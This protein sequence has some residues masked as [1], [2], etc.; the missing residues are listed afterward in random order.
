MSKC[1]RCGLCCM[2]RGDLAYGDDGVPWYEEIP[3]PALLFDEG[4]A[5]CDVY[6]C[7][8]SVCHD[9]PFS[10]IDD[11][12]CERQ[13][14]VAAVIGDHLGIKTNR[15]AS[16]W[17]AKI[18]SEDNFVIVA[19][20]QIHYAVKSNKIPNENNVEDICYDASNFTAFSRP[21]EIYI[22]E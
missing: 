12:L 21:N 16:N 10:D 13:L 1:L 2:G 20:C 7:R 15:N 17:F 3:C 19:G 8:L 18:G 5:S 14:R 4:V 22:A 11:G 9:Y 6:H